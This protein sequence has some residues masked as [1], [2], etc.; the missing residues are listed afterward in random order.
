MTELIAALS[1]VAAYIVV[2]RLL[3]PLLRRRRQPERQVECTC[4]RRLPVSKAHLVTA[5]FEGE[6]ERAMGGM[7]AVVAEYCPAH[8]PGGCNHPKEHP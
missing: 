6:E 5:V 8:C 3:P 2:R 4:G 1:A 7:T